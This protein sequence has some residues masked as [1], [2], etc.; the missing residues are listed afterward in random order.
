MIGYWKN[1]QSETSTF[2]LEDYWI[3][4]LF[5]QPTTLNLNFKPAYYHKL[6]KLSGEEVLLPS[7]KDIWKRFSFTNA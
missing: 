1:N 2:Q 7:Q 3:E 4:H 6:A 5:P